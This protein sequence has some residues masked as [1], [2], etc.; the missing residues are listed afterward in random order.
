METELKVIYEFGPFVLDPG[1]Q[2]LFRDDQ[3]VAITRKAFEILLA[4]VRCNGEAISKDD[5]LKTVWPDSFVEEANLSQNIFMLRKA[6]GDTAEERRY[7]V[8]LPG[9]GYRF[10][11]PIR[12]ISNTGEA[13]IA[14][15]RTRAEIV[16][17]ESGEAPANAPPP[18]LP[19]LR[20]SARGT[21]KWVWPGLIAAAVAFAATFAILLIRH[22]PP[23]S[24]SE[25]DSILVADFTNLTGDAVFDQTLRQGVEVQLQQSPYLGV[26]SED[27][28][29]HVLQLMGQSPEAH[30]AGPV[31]REACIRT[32]AAAMLE[33][34]I[35]TIGSQYL[36]DL[37]VTSCRSGGGLLDEQ[38]VQVARK[39]DV[40]GAVSRLTSAFRQQA[41]ESP[42][43]LQKHD[44]PLAEATT[45][46]LDAL[47]TFSLGVKVSSSQG[48]EAAI[49]FFKRAVEIDPNFAIAYA[50]L[51]LSYGATGSSELATE[52]A[53][54]AY[55]LRN[56][57][58][59]NER[60]FISAYYFGRAVGNQEKA[61]RICEEWAQT[62]PR[63]PVPHSFLAGFVDLVLADYA[64]AF[65][66]SRKLLELAPDS[67][68]PYFFA[69][70]NALLVD[71]LELSREAMRDAQARGL[72]DPDLL[73]VRYDLAFT[74]NDRPGMEQVVQAAQGKP[75]A[76][77][78]LADREAFRLAYAGHLTRARSLTREAIQVSQQQGSREGAAVFAVRAALREAF[79][80]DVRDA[81][82]DA[83][84]ALGLGKNREVSYGVAVALALAGDLRR[85]EALSADLERSYPE[86]TSIHFSYLPVIRAI[87]ELKRAHPAMAIEILE[88][89]SPYELGMPRCANTGYF[90]SLYPILIRGEAYLAAG[91]GPEA[92]REFQKVI[93]HHGSMIGDPVFSLAH[94]GLAR[95]YLASGEK[96]E[97]GAEFKQVL[98]IWKDADPDLAVVNKAK[99]DFA[100][101][102]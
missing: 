39:E 52:N 49:P 7:I 38:Q 27:R 80:G 75:E 66:E 88:S 30:L 8:T 56:R 10:A 22:H 97:A 45:A 73:L 43:T 25:K 86:D 41:G 69:G 64:Q 15:L 71:R 47:K 60:F 89:A 90:G 54:K 58:S 63:D 92:A 78:L 2:T 34:S 62:Y 6:L 33:G 83:A 44:L 37:R 96:A 21:R 17:E 40:L 50:Y 79:F 93:N 85:A 12:A 5:L 29:Q 65:A 36:L 24:I 18:P 91:K 70:Q 51:A 23:A 100:D 74:E 13:L 87:L 28:V 20:L 46:S 94:Y 11:A 77:G 61:R 57:A 32:G 19:S 76:M 99:A 53:R 4:L 35:R 42:S 98:A 48:D 55:E 101:L 84:T 67:A 95:S 1:R 26:L 82:D 102:Q 9:R 72:E 16:I 31:A 81:R 3:V 14:Q 59:D 68:Y